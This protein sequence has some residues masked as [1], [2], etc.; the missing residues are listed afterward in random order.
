M[1]AILNRLRGNKSPAQQVQLLQR[2]LDDLL[3]EDTREEPEV[4]LATVGR[5]GSVT[6]DPE[7]GE[8]VEEAPV[9]KRLRVMK[10]L[11]YGDGTKDVDEAKA[12]DLAGHLVAEGVMRRLLVHFHQLPFEARKYTSDLFTNFVRKPRA[13]FDAYLVETEDVLDML[14]HGYESQELGVLC[15]TM[16][17]E[18][19]RKPAL[20]RLVLY[21][22]D[23]IWPF[24]DDFVH[25]EDFALSSDAFSTLRQMLTENKDVAAEFLHEKFE[26]VFRRYDRLLN[27]ENYATKRQSIKLLSQ[28]LLDRK[29]YKVMIRYIS[30]KQNLKN[31]MMLLRDRHAN[32]QYEAFHVFKVFVANP[33]KSDGVLG[34][35]L[36]N[37]QKLIQF[38]SNFQN[39][40]EEEQFVEEKQLLIRTLEALQPRE[41]E[42]EAAAAGT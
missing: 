35:L 18:T 12:D 28:I 31:I 5:S 30:E 23:R 21:N 19:T 7:G 36:N 38:L 15:G 4:D 26:E 14:I 41:A 1:A 3:G 10:E 39:E 16:L 25:R 20:L 8:D 6:R 17:R 11:V 34:V 9:E 13:R 37:Q 29:N 2:A 24:F 33:N 42:A 32:I 22:E 27:S 40:K